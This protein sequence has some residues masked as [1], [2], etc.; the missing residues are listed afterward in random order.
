VERGGVHLGRGAFYPQ[1]PPGKPL[2][3]LAEEC[4]FS[5]QRG[6]YLPALDGE[7]KWDFTPAAKPG[8]DVVAGS[9]LGSVPEGIFEHYIIFFLMG[10][11]VQ[12]DTGQ[13]GA[14]LQL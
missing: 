14:F 6:T 13:W 7:K 11:I 9:I 4:G 10:A 8:D 2:P 1:E 3:E 12:E 5:L